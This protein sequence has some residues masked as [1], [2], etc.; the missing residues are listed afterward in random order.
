VNE[1]AAPRVISNSSVM[2]RHPMRFDRTDG[3]TSPVER[4][5]LGALGVDRL[6]FEARGTR[7]RVESDRQR[8][9]DEGSSLRPRGG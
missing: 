7:P 2:L 3:P 6:P 1:L 9:W 5:I 8:R 4:S